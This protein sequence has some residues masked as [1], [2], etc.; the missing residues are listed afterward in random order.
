MKYITI[1]SKHHDGFAMFGTKQSDWNIV[2]A[3][4]LQERRAEDAGRRMPPPGHQAVL[5]PLATGLAQ[6]GLF[7]ARPHRAR[8][9]PARER[10]LVNRYLD[11]MDAQLRELL[12][13][14][15]EIGGIW[16]DGMV[17]QAR[18]RLAPG[19]DLQARFTSLQPAALIGSNHHDCPF[20][21][22][23]S[24]CSRRTCRAHNTAGVQRRVEGRQPAAR[25]LRDHQQRLG[26][27]QQRQALQ[28]HRAID[29]VPGAGGGPQRQFSVEHRAD[30]ARAR[31]SRSS[32]SACRQ[33]GAVAGARTANPSTARAAGP[34]L[35]GLGA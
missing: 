2:D 10:R 16:F 28:E 23:I 19:E 11:Y 24:R 18:R 3:H 14:Y 35:R 32:S 29:S 20:P 4:A 26:L 5:L 17:G 9:G 1:T 13:D 25:N 15:G 30:A 27:Q 8:R 33:M 34:S 6:S 7:S 12:T 22:R 31:F 21:A